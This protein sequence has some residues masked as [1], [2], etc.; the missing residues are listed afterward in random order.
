[1][2][3]GRPD[4]DLDELRG[5]KFAPI[6][7]ASILADYEKSELADDVFPSPEAVAAANAC[8]SHFTSTLRRALTSAE[9]LGFIET[10][11]VNAVFAETPMPHTR[12]GRPK[13]DALTWS[14][15]FRLAWLV[16]FSQNGEP[17]SEAKQ[18]AAEGA[19]L[20]ENSATQTGSSFLLG[21][22]IMNRLLGSELKRKGWQKVLSNGSKYW[23]HVVYEK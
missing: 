11:Q 4:L 22:G 10:V 16:G 6:E 20:L 14:V 3:H 18:R 13:L 15:A 9:R 23:S 17:I 12:W 5:Q 8:V 1:M 7:V 19:V 2:R 21:H